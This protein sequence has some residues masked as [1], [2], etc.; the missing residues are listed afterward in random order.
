MK[1][2]LCFLLSC[3][4]VFNSVSVV[5]ADTKSTFNPYEQFK[6]NHPDWFD[7]NGNY[8]PSGNTCLSTIIAP[9]LIRAGETSCE[10][11]SSLADSVVD[12]IKSFNNSNGD[13]SVSYD[14]KGVPVT[15]DNYNENNF[16][17]T[18][19]NNFCNYFNQ[20]MQ[21]NVHALDGYFMIVPPQSKD[22]FDV[23]AFLLNARNNVVSKGLTSES[24]AKNINADYNITKMNNYVSKLSAFNAYISS[25]EAATIFGYSFNSTDVLYLDGENV[26][27][28]YLYSNNISTSTY[29]LSGRGCYIVGVKYVSSSDYPGTFN[30]NLG[31]S[32]TKLSDLRNIKYGAPMRVFYTAT[33]ARRYY[34]K[35]NT[36]KPTIIFA[37]KLPSDGVKIPVTYINNSVSLPDLNINVDSLVG[38]VEADIQA[39]LDLQL[40]NYFDK[41]VEFSTPE[42]TPTPELTATP[43]PKPT[44]T[45]TPEPS[46]TP[47]PNPTATPVPLPSATPTPPPDLG[48]LD[49]INDWLR[50]IYEWLQSFGTKHDEFFKTLSGYLESNNEKL[51]Q[52]IT[53]INALSNGKTE[54]EVNGCKYDF[55]QL[56]QSLTTLWNDSDQKFDQM[57]KLLEENNKYQEK[58]IG[59]LNDIKAILIAQTVL[60]VFQNR[61][62]ETADKAKEKFPTSIPWDIAMIVNTFSAEPEPIKFEL[63]IKVNSL[64]INET[65]TVDLSTGEWEKLG[66]L[67]RYMLS[68][69]FILFLIQL[70]RKLFSNGGDE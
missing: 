1:K 63:P 36:K 23:S 7:S 18:Y 47:T 64:N 68:V 25:R 51:D 12:I 28:F 31:S 61:S 43:T 4:L 24:N 48:K 65:I 20:Q 42:A 5:Y 35:L 57:I 59:D 26:R 16:Y 52:I 56:S 39:N 58:I 55:T 30:D 15:A 70:S 44:A 6:K 69:L 11:V 32:T 67:C 21:D 54:D 27:T 53:A 10:I 62:K 41:L 29:S 9:A 19:N 46:A 38:K 49:E 33:D 8:I 60:D 66:K 40:K 34:E 13:I 2:L 14:D 45:P 50:K 3:L 22:S 17:L 37:P